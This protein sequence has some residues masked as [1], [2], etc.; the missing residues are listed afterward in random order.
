[1]RAKRMLW[2]YGAFLLLFS[3]MVG[4]L[5]LLASNQNYAQNAENQTVTTLELPPPRGQIYDMHRNPLTGVTKQ[6]YALALPGDDSYVNLFQYVPYQS[7]TDLY[8]RANTAAVPFLIPVQ[9]DLSTQGIFSVSALRREMP[10]PIAVHIL[11]YLDQEGHGISGVEQAFDDLLFQSQSDTIHCATTA[12]GSLMED[13]K[14]ILKTAPSSTQGVQ[15]TLDRAIQR[16]AEGVAI[17]EM[18]QGS[19]LILDTKTAEI[20]AA[21]SMPMFDPLNI[22]KSIQAEDTSLIN[23]NFSAF[24]VGSV[25]KPFLA[26]VALEKYWNPQTNYECKGWIDIDGQVYRCVNGIPHGKINLTQALAQSCNCYFVEMGSWLGGKEILKMAKEVGFGKAIYFDAGL[27]SASG[28]LPTEQ[29]LESSGELANFSFGQGKFTATPVQVA[30]M[31]NVFANQGK[32]IQ[33]TLVQGIVQE[34]TGTLEPSLYFEQE[35]QLFS[36]KTATILQ[37]MLQ[38]VVNNGLG[39]KA[40]PTFGGAAGKTGTA[41]TG[42]FNKEK[43]E[44]TDVWFAGFWPAKEPK[45]TIVVL[46]D[47]TLEQSGKAAKIFAEI[48]NSLEYLHTEVA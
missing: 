19:I 8:Q 42:R 29:E 3:I 13:T 16:I 30:A 27:K 23:R 43:K 35:K 48:C 40:L 41:Q 34:G 46:L 9:Q 14:P 26:A 25:F 38:G 20:R 6:W 24:N 10:L 28:T 32:Y 22:K 21:V 2:I 31:I 7:Q 45:Y 36:E 5:Y 11:G 39:S 12:R 17:S 44:L 37:K 47:S 18:E 33:P 15:L 1:M 4:R